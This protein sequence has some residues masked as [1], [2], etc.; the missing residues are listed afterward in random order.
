MCQ[1]VSKEKLI[2]ILHKMKVAQQ[3]QSQGRCDQ[4]L[5]GLEMLKKSK[6]LCECIG[7][8]SELM[9]SRS[10][11]WANQSHTCT[12]WQY[13]GPGLNQPRSL[14]SIAQAVALR[15]LCHSTWKVTGEK[16]RG[17]EWSPSN[18]SLQRGKEL[19]ARALPS[20]AGEATLMCEGNMI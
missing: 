3:V 16:G 2:K 11:R 8:K 6:P 4:S 15:P 18:P 7:R 19:Q 13:P 17:R 10:S 5:N 14:H 1:G 9:C 20:E 12:V